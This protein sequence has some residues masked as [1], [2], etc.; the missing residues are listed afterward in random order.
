MLL[1]STPKKEKRNI[2]GVERVAITRAETIKAA[3]IPV[4][5]TPSLKLNHKPMHRQAPNRQLQRQVPKPRLS[6][7]T[8][9]G[10][11]AHALVRMGK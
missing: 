8:H 6:D 4:K 2:I 1:A 9:L 10:S 5:I 3:S 11:L 7:Q